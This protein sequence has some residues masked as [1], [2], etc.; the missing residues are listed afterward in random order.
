MSDH[1]DWVEDAP[2]YQTQV[3]YTDD[4]SD[5]DAEHPTEWVIFRRSDGE[6]VATGW[7]RSPQHARELVKET[8][9]RL[10]STQV[11]DE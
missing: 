2:D 5:P 1:L 11:G 3:F 8:L 10:R 9:A 7:G 6:Q 4:A